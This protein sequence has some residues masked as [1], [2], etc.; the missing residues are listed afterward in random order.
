MQMYIFLF[1]NKKKKHLLQ[2][3]RWERLF[4]VILQTVLQIR[5]NYCKTIIIRQTRFWFNQMLRKPFK[6]R[7]MKTFH[8]FLV[9]LFLIAIQGICA[10][11]TNYQVKKINGTEYILYPVQPGEGLF[12]IGRKFNIPV[13]E[14][15]ELNP[16]VSGGLKSG[17]ILLIPNKNNSKKTETIAEKPEKQETPV[18]VKAE[19]SGDTEYIEHVVEKKQTL[20]AISR[21][22]DIS[23]D[24]IK[25]L[26]PQLEDGLKTGMVLRIPKATTDKKL[27][28]KEK[29]TQ[30]ETEKPKSKKNKNAA[31]TVVI[32]HTVKAKETL[33][34]ISKLYNVDVK[35]IIKLNPTALTSLTIGSELDI[36]VKKEIADKLAENEENN[37]PEVQ[38][39]VKTQYSV[40]DV[41]YLT[42]LTQ[43]VKPNQ[44]PIKIGVLLP[45][46]I[47]NIKTDAVNE[48]FQ[49]FYAGFLL[50]VNEAKQKGVSLE[51]YTFDTEKSEEKISLILQHP[52]LKTV[53]LIIGPAYSNMISLVSDFARENKINT[54]IPFSSKVPDVVGNPYLFQFNPSS[55]V[56]SEYFSNLLIQKYKDE[57]IVFVDL[58]TSSFNDNGYE[59]SQDIKEILTSKNRSFK[60]IEAANEQVVQSATVFEA[61]KTNILI[62]NTDKF[63]ALFP[64]LS[65]LNAKAQEYNILLYE[66]FSWKN[67]NAQVKFKSFSV[68]PFKP[69]LN[70]SVYNKYNDLFS[71]SFSWKP[72]SN[73]PRYDILGYDLGNYFIALIYEFGSQ[74]NNGKSKLPLASGVQSFLKFERSTTTNGFVNKQLYQHEK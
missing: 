25:K 13:N 61:G 72:S 74:F 37:K 4:L 20:F 27:K 43:R 19:T 71:A 34:A 59:F 30:E 52:T 63:S 66:Q 51:I 15:S 14:I 50:A 11:D 6:L 22:Y 42:R 60:V 31:K 44:T 24:D 39:V 55:K 10:Q 2:Q 32:R 1:K 16:D 46:V 38:E 21:K 45:L 29:E 47:E 65:F 54:I 7:R 5:N 41:Q 57:N 48:R 9:A 73:N 26:N 56:E 35:D 70:D 49:D 18:I 58:A 3:F 40:D 69:V 36:E 33:Y 53:D 23:Q 64:Y 28:K 17:Q 62:F 67:Q 68:A 8:A 12:A